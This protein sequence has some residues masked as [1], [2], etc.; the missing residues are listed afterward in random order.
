[1]ISRLRNCIVSLVTQRVMLYDTSILYC[2]EASLPHQIKDILK[3]EVMEE[4]VMETRQ[5][6]L[7]QEG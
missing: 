4:I 3:P 5:R 2:Y 1:M 7:E 6:L